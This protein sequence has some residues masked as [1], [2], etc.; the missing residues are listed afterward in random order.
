MIADVWDILVPGDMLKW[1][2]CLTIVVILSERVLA[3][4]KHFKPQLIR[5]SL[6]TSEKERWATFRELQKLETDLQAQLKEQRAYLHDEIH[7]L[8][9]DF[10]NFCLTSEN[11]R[12]GIHGRINVICE[13]LYELRGLIRSREGIKP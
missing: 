12:E 4:L 3:L 7:K 13:V 1:L 10:Q 6:T 11:Q 9:G 5:G 8:R 2:A